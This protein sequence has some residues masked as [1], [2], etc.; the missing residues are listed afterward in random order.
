M[1]RLSAAEL[2]QRT[3]NLAARVGASVSIQPGESV[4][5]GGATPDLA[6]P[7]WLVVLNGKDA[8]QAERQ[9]RARATPIIGRIEKDRLV[10]DLRTVFPDQEDA[11]AEA[12]S[13]L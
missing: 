2:R 3:E 9:L 1:I 5:G 12:L 6:L 8:N 7:T 4:I 10:L 11:V 13:S